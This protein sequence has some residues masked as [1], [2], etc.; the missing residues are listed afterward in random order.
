M[1]YIDIYIYISIYIHIYTHMHI[2][3]HLMS[4]YIHAQCPTCSIS[5]HQPTHPWPLEITHVM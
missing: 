5:V 1:V 3:I 4:T 2:A